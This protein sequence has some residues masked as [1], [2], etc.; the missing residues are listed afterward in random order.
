MH[1]LPPLQPRDDADQWPSGREPQSPSGLGRWWKP[2]RIEALEVDARVRDLDPP[3]RAQRALRR[4]NRARHRYYA[5]GRESDRNPVERVAARRQAVLTPHGW[6]AG[7]PRGRPA[8]KLR[9]RH[10]SDHDVRAA[11]SERRRKPRDGARIVLNL[12]Q[13]PGGDDRR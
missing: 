5:A 1:A 10:P 2:V 6:D 12:A 4:P 11:A 7:K 9:L 13:P 8:V 3:A